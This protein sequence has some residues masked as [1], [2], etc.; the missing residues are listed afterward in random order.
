LVGGELRVSGGYLL[1]LLVQFGVPLSDVGAVAALCGVGGVGFFEFGHEAGLPGGDVV[2]LPGGG[3]DRAGVLGRFAARFGVFLLGLVRLSVWA[4]HSCGDEVRY[5][6]YEDVFADVEGAGVF[7]SGAAAGGVSWSGAFVVHQAVAAVALHPPAAVSAVQQPA[8]QVG[9]DGG[10]LS[11]DL[12]A[13]S[14]SLLVTADR[15]RGA[16]LLQADQFRVGLLLRPHPLLDRV[17]SVGLL[18]LDGHAGAGGG[19]V[20]HHV[21]GVLRVL[22]DRPHGRPGPDADRGPLPD[23]DGRR[24]AVGVFVEFGGDLPEGEPVDHPPPE[25]LGHDRAACR[26]DCQFGAGEPA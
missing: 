21:A 1:A 19:A 11:V 20:P 5:C 26:I 10:A 8:Q 12:S 7:G 24:V 16:E 25:D 14:G 23:R 3:L 6:G 2:Q 15:L 4:E 22:Q 9:V 18:A 13:G 17:G